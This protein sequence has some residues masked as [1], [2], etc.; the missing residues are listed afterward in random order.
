MYVNSRYRWT[1][2]FKH[3]HTQVV[4]MGVLWGIPMALVGRE[5]GVK[6][7]WDGG[8]GG[9]VQEGKI[10]TTTEL[11]KKC[12]IPPYGYHYFN[13]YP[14]Y[15]S[16]GIWQS[17][18][19]GSNGYGVWLNSRCISSILIRPWKCHLLLQEYWAHEAH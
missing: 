1:H 4:I 17:L 11:R 18:F 10:E 13:D 2:T 8:W 6:V 7:C 14:S 15:I 16:P 19:T 5:T 9:W 12:Q 3:I